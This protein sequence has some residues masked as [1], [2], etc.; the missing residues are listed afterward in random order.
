MDADCPIQIITDCSDLEGT[1]YVE[2]MSGAYEN[3]CWNEGS[4]FFEEEVFGY[5]EP[6]IT[7]YEPTYDHYAFTPI[8]MPNWLRIVTTLGELRRALQRQPARTS[9]LRQIGFCFKNSETR[10]LEHFDTNCAALAALIAGIEGWTHERL[11]GYDR[12][13]ILGI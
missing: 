2:L 9:V 5:L 11:T 4:L 12:V 6:T 7:R 1:A 3:K 13:T 10:F 8:E